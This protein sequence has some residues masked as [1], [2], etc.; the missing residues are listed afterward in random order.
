MQAV[1]AAAGD[2]IIKRKLQIV[3][4][5]EP[6]ESRPG[7]AAPAAVTSY[8]V[9]LQTR[10]DRAGGFKRLLIEAGLLTTLAIE[11][12]RTDGHKVA[13]DFAALRFEQPIQRFETGGNHAIIRAS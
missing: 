3:V 4:A 11:A 2:G 6:V 12:L 10:R 5:E 8:A 9:G 7:F 13:V 1:A